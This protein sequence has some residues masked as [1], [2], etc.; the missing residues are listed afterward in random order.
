MVLS[1]VSSRR[2]A[3]RL[4]DLLL[5]KRVAACINISSPVES[6]YWWKGK[7]EKAKEFLLLI[8]TTA[9]AFG[10]LEKLLRENH[11]YA[12]PEIIALPVTRGTRKYLAWLDREIRPNG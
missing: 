9:P 4:A 3:R 5:A 7:K 6:R 11:S 10:K 8:K 12:S 1:T 2:E